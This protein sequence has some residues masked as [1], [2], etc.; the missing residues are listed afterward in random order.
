LR[1]SRHLAFAGV[2][3]I[4]AA[5]VA[6]WCLANRAVRMDSPFASPTFGIYYLFALAGELLIGLP[7]ALGVRALLRR[8]DLWSVVT[9]TASAS[10]PGMLL[11]ALDRPLG[12]AGQVLGPCVLIAG[13]VM[14]A[15]WYL[16]RYD[17]PSRAA[18]G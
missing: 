6:W 13:L 14:A 12:G 4:G 3:L 11:I 17:T 5:L 10:L 9:M 1:F 15:G 18:H 16:L 7:Y 8:L 2:M